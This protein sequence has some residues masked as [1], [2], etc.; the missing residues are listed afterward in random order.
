MRFRSG[1][2]ATADGPLTLDHAAR[3]QLVRVVGVSGGRRLVHRLAAL[4]VVP[5]VVFT[6]V[7]PSG[8]ALIMVGGARIAVGHTAA[9]AIEVEA[10]TR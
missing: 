8:P 1:V 10:V 3:S 5:G 9:Q 2:A 6:V 4:G 7:R